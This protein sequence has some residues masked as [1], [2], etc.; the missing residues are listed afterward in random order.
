MYGVHERPKRGLILDIGVVQRKKKW[1]IIRQENI[2][3][4]SHKG[5]ISY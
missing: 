5:Q 2:C 3:F 4:I 1:S